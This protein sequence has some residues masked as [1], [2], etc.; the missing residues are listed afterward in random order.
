MS[1]SCPKCGN[2]IK[3]EIALRLTDKNNGIDLQF[4]PELERINYLSGRIKVKADRLAIGY[5]ELVEKMLIYGEKL[6]DRIIE[7]IK[8]Q[9]LEKSE[10]KDITIFLNHVDSNKLIFHIHGLKPDR[11]GV[12]QIPRRVYDKINGS[13]MQLLNDKN[14]KLFTKPPYISVNRIFLEE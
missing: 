7:I 11:L 4:L 10:N 6:D 13:L 5:K 3:T 2:E 14:I 1:F 12:S 9:L 8:F